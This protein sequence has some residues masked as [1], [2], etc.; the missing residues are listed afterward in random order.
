L[1]SSSSSFCGLN[2]LPSIF[3]V[4]FTIY[5]SVS[6]FF[7]IAERFGV[8]EEVR[9]KKGHH[10]IVPSQGSPEP[11]EDTQAVPQTGH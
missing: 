1:S 3:T 10:Y 5:L 2:E 8:N 4:C 6:R 11:M 9:N 7:P